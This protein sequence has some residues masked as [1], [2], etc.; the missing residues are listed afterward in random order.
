MSI[1]I[2]DIFKEQFV[3][4]KEHGVLME[5][6]DS[7][8]INPTLNEF[9]IAC[10][11]IHD[12]ICIPHDELFTHIGN[13]MVAIV[14]AMR[15]SMDQSDLLV[16]RD[17]VIKALSSNYT[18]KEVANR[19]SSYFH[20]HVC[21]GLFTRIT[22]T[23]IENDIKPLYRFEVVTYGANEFYDG[24]C[25]TV[26]KINTISRFIRA[27]MDPGKYLNNTNRNLH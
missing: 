21:N 6:S 15:P 20:F 14:D 7:L 22:I 25:Q 16:F 3:S 2:F 27:C 10:V 1:F 11:N 17:G 26:E 23:H 5:G 13:I 9:G 19:S 8:Y 24:D 4:G 18:D 12:Y